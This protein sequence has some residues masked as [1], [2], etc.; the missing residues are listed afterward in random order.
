MTEDRQYRKAISKQ[1][2]ADEI[3]KNAGTQFDPTLAKLF[4]EKIMLQESSTI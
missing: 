3:L 1:E 4:V 2:A